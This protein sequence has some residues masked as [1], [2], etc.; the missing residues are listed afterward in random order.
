MYYQS[1][2]PNLQRMQTNTSAD[3]VAALLMINLTEKLIN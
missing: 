1:H 2:G 3:T